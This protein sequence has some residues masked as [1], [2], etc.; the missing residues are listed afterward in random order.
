[1]QSEVR[2]RIKKREIAMAVDGLTELEVQN[3]AGQVEKKM[4][5]IEK[6]SGQPDT[7]KLAILAAMEFAIALHNV[8]HKLEND[9]TADARMIDEMTAALEG[10]LDK[11]LF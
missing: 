4:D 10:A 6:K 1:M 8:K 11:K 3:I 2:V 7:S 9:K 5:D